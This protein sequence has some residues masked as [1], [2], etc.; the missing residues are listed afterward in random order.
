[1]KTLL[2]DNLLGVVLAFSLL[3]SSHLIAGETMKAAPEKKEAKPFSLKEWWEGPSLTYDWFGQGAKMREHGIYL[4]STL[5]QFGQG[6]V[7]GRGN[8]D[9]E[10]GG[11]L[12]AFG[13]LEGEPM[14]TWPGLSL[15][16]HLMFLYGESVIGNGGELSPTN[17]ALLLPASNQTIVTLSSLYITQKYGDFSLSAGRYN[18]V[19][20]Y[21]LNAFDGGRG[22]TSFWNTAVAMPL[23]AARAVPAVTLG[24]MAGYSNK[25]LGLDL[26]FAVF[27]PT[28]SETT[29][30]LSDPFAKGVTLLGTAAVKTKFGGLAGKQTVTGVWSN[31]EANS[32]TSTR[33]LLIP[34]L[35]GAPANQD[36]TWFFNYSMEQYL[37]QYEGAETKG[38]GLFGSLGISDGNPNPIDWS[39]TFGLGGDSPIQGRAQDRFGVGYYFLGVSS[40]MEKALPLLLPVRDEQGVEL[41]YTFALNKWWTVTAD[42]Q[43]IDPWTRRNETDVVAGMSTRIKF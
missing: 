24:A 34:S 18:T 25:G 3:A 16:S 4:E 29:T 43:V 10:Y 19:D 31:V 23:I 1:M 20:F 17:T 13:H 38:F 28:G 27:D 21:A 11:L 39:A 14:G 26:N 35:P 33:Q 7:S 9:W 22:V 2:K 8:R 12:D 37:V 40:A 32:L 30:G 5:T 41:F 6:L 42:V 15:D 36:D